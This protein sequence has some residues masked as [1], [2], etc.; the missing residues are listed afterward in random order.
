MNEEKSEIIGDF[1]W[2]KLNDNPV[3]LYASPSLLKN[4]DLILTFEIFS[5]KYQKA[6]KKQLWL[7][8]TNFNRYLFHLPLIVVRK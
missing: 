6:D 7:I 2:R 8:T 1:L 5:L 4:V 3:S